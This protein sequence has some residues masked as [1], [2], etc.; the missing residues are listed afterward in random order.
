MNMRYPVDEFFYESFFDVVEESGCYGAR[1]ITRS[2]MQGNVGEPSEP[3]NLNTLVAWR[4]GILDQLKID[5]D[6]P[7]ANEEY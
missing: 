1:F 5:Q 6:S 7:S 4:Q 2:S 3:K